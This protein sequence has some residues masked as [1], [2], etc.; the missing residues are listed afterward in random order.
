MRS[1][2]K[3]FISL[4]V[5]GI[6]LI[7]VF[8]VWSISEN[9]IF[10]EEPQKA[11][12][13]E[14]KD[15]ILIPAYVTEDKALYFFIKDSNNLGAAKINNGLFGWKSDYLVWSTTT[16]TITDEKFNGYQT[17]GDEIIFGL[18]KNGQDFTVMADDIPAEKINLEVSL[19]N[20]S[21]EMDLENVYLWYI[22][23]DNLSNIKELIL[24]NQNTN[25]ELDRHT[26]RD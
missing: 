3:L 4:I 26:Y 12:L 18:M 13:G 5:L 19:H 25:E 15:L 17:D 8:T 22:E 21:V 11:L 9:K 24:V 10:Y 23:S 2:S 20:E 16:G 14:N 1:H 6:I 7:T